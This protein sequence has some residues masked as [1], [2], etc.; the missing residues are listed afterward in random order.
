MSMLP[1]DMPDSSRMACLP[2]CCDHCIMDISLTD[3]SKIM[4]QEVTGACDFENSV[5]ADIWYK[6][7]RRVVARVV[8]LDKAWR[9]Y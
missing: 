7:A 8:R 2:H 1:D 5:E 9:R 4:Y 3:L 6:H